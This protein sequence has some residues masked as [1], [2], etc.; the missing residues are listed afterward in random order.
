MYRYTA[1]VKGAVLR[2][3]NSLKITR[4]IRRHYGIPYDRS[5]QVGKDPI[6]LKRKN[7]AGETICHDV[8][9]WIAKK[10]CI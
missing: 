6:R 1:V 8:M 2:M 10:V 7:A 4:V 9:N 5:F 3:Q